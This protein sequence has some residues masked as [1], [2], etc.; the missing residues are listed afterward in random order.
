MK[1]LIKIFSIF[2]LFSPFVQAQSGMWQPEYVTLDDGEHGTGFLTSSV[3]VLGPNRFVA[4]ITG[5]EEPESDIFL[6]SENYLVGYWDADSVRGRVTDQAYAPYS[7][8]DIWGTSENEIIL[9]G[10]WQITG[11]PENKLYVANNDEDHTILVFELTASGVVST[12]YSM[13][14]GKETIY[15]IAVAGN[16]DVFVAD[17]RGTDEKKDELKIFPSIN[18][19]PSIWQSTDKSGSRPVLSIDLPAG[20]F[21]G[22]AANSNASQIYVSCASSREILRYSGDIDN[23]YVMDSFFNL[24]LEETDVVSN[25]G[26]GVPTFLG[27]AYSDPKEYLFAATDVFLLKGRDGAYPYGRINVFESVSG[28]PVD[29]ID[30]AANNLAR[31]GEYVRGSANGL[32]GG[33]A[34]VYD[35]EVDEEISVYTQT[36]YGWAVEKWYNLFGPQ[37]TQVDEKDFEY[38]GLIL[39]QNYPNPFSTTTRISF[40]LPSSSNVRFEVHN[41]LGQRILPPIDKFYEQGNHSIEFDGTLLSSGIYLYSFQVGSYHTKVMKMLLRR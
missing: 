12:P 24:Q 6:T 27:L 33:Y 36:Y 25:G 35:V 16:G 19:N 14:T 29:T 41:L 1:N 21:Q 37:Y 7:Q 11:G 5:P 32:A 40:T 38:P 39:E 30:I 3:A 26:S 28:I 13:P 17:Y 18:S 9:N 4:L 31:I 20:I 23:G 15:A 8:R 34:S 22:L 2:L 10:A